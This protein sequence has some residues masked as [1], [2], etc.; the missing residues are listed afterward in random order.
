M[1]SKIKWWM[2][3]A[4]VLLL[5]VGFT[6]SFFG[7]PGSPL[8]S[9]KK[10]REAVI[11]KFTSFSS[12]VSKA[13][14]NLKLAEKRID[15]F[16]SLKTETDHLTTPELISLDGIQA[17]LKRVDADLKTVRIRFQAFNSKIKSQEVES[18]L[19]KF[20]QILKG[21]LDSTTSRQKSISGTE[22]VKQLTGYKNEFSGLLEKTEALKADLADDQRLNESLAPPRLETTGFIKAEDS[23]FKLVVNAT[24]FPVKSTRYNLKDYQDE[25]VKIEGTL[26]QKGILV[27]EN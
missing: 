15:E 5:A 7:K 8:F 18:L 13:D 6:L 2:V 3:L 22:E 4:V 26:T 27:L 16:N 10:T 12:V 17:A 1:L 23:L 14:Y 25:L 20:S 19:N 21:Q 9:L 24:T 11:G